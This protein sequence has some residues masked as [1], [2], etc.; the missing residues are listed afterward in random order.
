MSTRTEL[1]ALLALKIKSGNSDTTAEDLRDFET[2][3][4]D[5]TVNK[6]DDA[7]AV[8]GFLQIDSDS[9]VDVS[10][11][12]KATPTGQYLK[13]DGTW[14]SAVTSV[15]SVADFFTDVPNVGTTE[16][17]LFTYNSPANQLSALGDKLLFNFSGI[18]TDVSC[19]PQIRFYF[20]SQLI[21]DTTAMALT[22][23][24]VSFEVS[25]MIIKVTSSV[26][27]SFL[28]FIGSDTSGN[29]LA[30]YQEVTGLD[31]T[32]INRIDMTAEATTGGNADI[33][34]KMGTITYSARQ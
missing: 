17:V 22:A 18:I 27:R 33:I 30:Q 1:E 6:E 32:K 20:D 21:F 2:E 12:K 34:G 26:A 5:S 31:F 4:I 16:T 3:I 28:K 8:D 23:A 15:Y 10:F 25:G 13:D 9:K 19:G 29:T 24:P 7:N 14:D 11:I